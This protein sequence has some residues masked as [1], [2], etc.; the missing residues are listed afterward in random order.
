[1]ICD[2]DYTASRDLGVQAPRNRTP[3]RS[4][5]PRSALEVAGWHG[6]VMAGG[7]DRFDMAEGEPSLHTVPIGQS[8]PL[9]E[10]DVHQIHCSTYP[11]STQLPSRMGERDPGYARIGANRET[12]VRH[13]SSLQMGGKDFGAYAQVSDLPPAHDLRG[14]FAPH[15][16]PPAPA[17]SEFSEWAANT[18]QL[19]LRDNSGGKVP[20]VHADVSLPDEARA[21]VHSYTH[22]GEGAQPLV[23]SASRDT[24]TRTQPLRRL[25]S[26]P[27]RDMQHEHTPIPDKLWSVP[28]TYAVVAAGAAAQLYAMSGTGAQSTRQRHVAGTQTQRLQH[29]PSAYTESVDQADWRLSVNDDVYMPTGHGTQ[30]VHVPPLNTT[31]MYTPGQQAS[32]TYSH[33]V[34]RCDIGVMPG[35]GMDVHSMAGGPMDSGMASKSKSLAD[36]HTEYGSTLGPQ[37]SYR[38]SGRAF[39]ASNVTLTSS[40]ARET[41]TMQNEKNFAKRNTANNVANS[42]TENSFN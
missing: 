31:T 19:S 15:A 41:N 30:Q 40:V 24:S 35:S 39:D 36:N 18:T 42:N 17:S 34:P 25:E 32:T 22:Y 28:L 13:E 23:Q 8:V 6:D 5:M 26:L 11:T 9:S 10:H 7:G 16:G 20:H 33:N 38:I 21:C 3:S 2:D 37:S 29:T 12:S 14:N 27:T 4:G 1:M